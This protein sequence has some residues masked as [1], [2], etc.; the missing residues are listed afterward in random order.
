MNRFL[1]LNRRYVPRLF[2]FESNVSIRESKHFD[3]LHT[4]T[5]PDEVIESDAPCL[6]RLVEAQAEVGGSVVAARDAWR[7]SV[8]QSARCWTS[9]DARGRPSRDSGMVEKPDRARVPSSLAVIGRHV[10]APEVIGHPGR[11]R[12]GTGRGEMSL[13]DAIA[14]EIGTGRGV[15]ALS[16]M[17]R[18]TT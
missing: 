9:A 17:R 1:G 11:L 10:L 7:R 18:C 6:A 8:C 5:L 4:V 12:R 15:N 14:M 2:R 13:A 16:D 3:S